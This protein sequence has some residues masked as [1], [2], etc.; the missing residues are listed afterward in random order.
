MCNH[1]LEKNISEVTELLQNKC[2]LKPSSIRHNYK[3]G[4]NFIRHHYSFL[5]Q[6]SCS[7]TFLK[8]CLEFANCQ[9]Y[10]SKISRYKF[11]KIR[12]ATSV[13]CQYLSTGTVD[14]ICLP[15]HQY[16]IPL[17]DNEEILQGH[18]HE[19]EKRLNKSSIS[20]NRNIIRQFLIFIEDSGIKDLSVL[21]NENVTSFLQYMNQRRPAGLSTVVPAVRNFLKYLY[22]EGFTHYDLHKSADIKVVRHHRIY[23]TFSESELQLIMGQVDTTCTIGKRDYAILMLA[24][25]NGLRSSDITG[26]KLT[27]ID[28]KRAEFSIVQQKTGNPIACPMDT[29]TG[30]AIADYILNARP[31]SSLP[32][33]FL[34]IQPS[35]SLSSAALCAILKKYMDATGII[36]DPKE[37][38][39]MHTFRRTLATNLLETG[40]PLETIAQV[41]GHKDTQSTKTYLT[42]SEKKLAECA[43]GLNEFPSLWRECHE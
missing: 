20:R 21:T 10:S 8:E 27:D 39:S 24:S 15:P 9:Y 5:K 1:S 16:R 36:R 2:N 42:I 43:L 17:A 38:K 13:L 18:I 4:F 40:V 29:S 25:H 22:S 23:A 28:W 11:L 31:E 37:R 3:P 19:E 6:D 41:L 7:I 34:K 32:H 33:I 12:K 26:M 30:N 14:S 35:G